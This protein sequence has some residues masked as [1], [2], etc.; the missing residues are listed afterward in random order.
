MQLVGMSTG[1]SC[2][3]NVK[4]QG[5]LSCSASSWVV[6][7]WRGRE[8]KEGESTQAHKVEKVLRVMWMESPGKFLIGGEVLG[9]LSINFFIYLNFLCESCSD[10][11]AFL[12]VVFFSTGNMKTFTAAYLYET[13]SLYTW[14]HMHMHDSF[15]FITLTQVKMVLWC[16]KGSVD[17]AW[18]YSAA[19]TPNKIVSL[20]HRDRLLLFGLH[21][22]SWTSDL[23][24][25]YYPWHFSVFFEIGKKTDLNVTLDPTAVS[26]LNMCR[27]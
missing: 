23:Q 16:C 17:V 4:L 7:E 21:L 24:D 12:C 11:N 26:T 6:T 22:S 20:L 10:G 2:H 15:S 27:E 25:C 8:G 3:G 9:G 13:I 5:S 1:N 19:S 18:Q 14:R